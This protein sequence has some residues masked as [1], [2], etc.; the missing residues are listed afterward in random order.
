MPEDQDNISLFFYYLNNNEI[1]LLFFIIYIIYVCVMPED[2]YNISFLI[3][4]SLYFLKMIFHYESI[5]HYSIRLS[6]YFLEIIF[7][8]LIHI[9]LIH[10]SLFILSSGMTHTCGT[11]FWARACAPLIRAFN[12]HRSLLLI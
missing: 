11:T 5:F 12:R 10:I 6:L 7:S 1:I 2:Q 4:L 3:R 9:S 8:L